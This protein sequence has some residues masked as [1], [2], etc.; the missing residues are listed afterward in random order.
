[1]P[2]ETPAAAPLDIEFPLR[3]RAEDAEGASPEPRSGILPQLFSIEV[4]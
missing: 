1:M 2:P 4:A 3:T